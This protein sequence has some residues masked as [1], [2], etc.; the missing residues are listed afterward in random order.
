MAIDAKPTLD[1]WYET[2]EGSVFR[3]TVINDKDNTIEIQS[4]DGNV[5]ELGLDDWEDL[6]VK[7]VQAPEDWQGLLD[8]T[9]TDW[10]DLQK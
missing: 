5:D 4:L 6:A 2:E 1:A 3:V 8:E 9:P 10:K 7:E